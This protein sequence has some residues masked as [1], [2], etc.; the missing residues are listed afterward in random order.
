MKKNNERK[1]R[2]RVRSSAWLGIR[3]MVNDL[4]RI[5]R[6]LKIILAQ[7]ACGCDKKTMQ[8]EIK[9]LGTTNDRTACECCGKSGLAL[10]VVLEINGA[11]TYYGRDCAGAAIMGKKSAAFTA[12]VSRRAAAVDFVNR[13]LGKAAME[14]VL[15]VAYNRFGYAVTME[16]GK[17]VVA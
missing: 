1:T 15:A 16:D 4:G 6:N 10:T 17:A 9:T 2:G 7:G 8:N 11:I 3:Q 5:V 14:K 12:G 13:N